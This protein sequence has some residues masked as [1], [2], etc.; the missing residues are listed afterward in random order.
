MDICHSSSG[1]T[2]TSSSVPQPQVI[3]LSH[4]NEIINRQAAEITEL[5]KQLTKAESD[6]SKAVAKLES[7]QM[8]MEA[9][10]E[11]QTLSLQTQIQTMKEQHSKEVS[12]LHVRSIFL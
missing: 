7:Q 2:P 10:H 8:V 6:H 11:Q 3:D 12:H 9:Q 4:Y 1:P 5:R